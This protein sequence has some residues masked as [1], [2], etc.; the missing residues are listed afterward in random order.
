MSETHLIGIADVKVVTH[1]DRIRTTLGS[2]IGVAIYDRVTKKGGMAHVMLPTSEG[3]QGDKGKF[4]DTAVDWLVNEV[5]G[6]GCD[7]R[8]IAAKIAGGAS[9]FG[10][11]TDN[12]LGERNA[13]AVKDR[14][15]KHNIRL[16]AE[17][18]G[19]QKGRRMLLAPDTGDVEVQII[20]E[21]PCMI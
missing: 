20:G 15:K 1:P 5:I 14:L 12:G 4:A 10:P 2:C 18:I 19:G 7:R 17:H 8:R 21:E 3:C 9:M 13:N 11:A 16:V 6:A